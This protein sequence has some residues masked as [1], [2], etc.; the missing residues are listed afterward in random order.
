M[1][2]NSKTTE[3]CWHKACPESGFKLLISVSESSNPVYTLD[4]TEIFI[5]ISSIKYRNNLSSYGRNCNQG[6]K[7]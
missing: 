3:K 5:V 2:C 6:L 4:H 7:F 1:L